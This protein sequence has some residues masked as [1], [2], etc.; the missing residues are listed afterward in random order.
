LNRSLSGCKHKLALITRANAHR[1]GANQS[2]RRRHARRSSISPKRAR[3]LTER[4]ASLA[5]ARDNP[6][7]TP[8]TQGGPKAPTK[9]ISQNRT[10]DSL[11]LQLALMADPFSVRPYPR[12]Q[13]FATLEQN[14]MITV[15]YAKRGY[16]RKDQQQGGQEAS[17]KSGC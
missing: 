11:Y 7:P 5:S 3:C 15:L 4:F 8:K 16:E 9:T 6:I 13:E 17:C 2:R 14:L 1:S 12:C 10:D